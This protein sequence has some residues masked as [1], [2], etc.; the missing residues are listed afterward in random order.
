MDI[1]NGDGDL[2]DKEA[3]L[4]VLSQLSLIDGEE[5][6]ANG[7]SLPPPCPLP[8]FAVNPRL[9]VSPV[10]HPQ[11]TWRSCLRLSGGSVRGTWNWRVTPAGCLLVISTL[12]SNNCPLRC[13]F[14][15][16][17]H[18]FIPCPYHP[19]H[20]S[21]EAF[22]KATGELEASLPERLHLHLLTILFR[23]SGLRGQD[24]LEL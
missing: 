4:A 2:R 14:H 3:A 20:R 18:A 8:A 7:H 15:T 17:V 6:A 9:R 22:L 13:A 21:F 11:K 12:N 19:P 5:N 23:G 16:V 10:V 24:L 1:L